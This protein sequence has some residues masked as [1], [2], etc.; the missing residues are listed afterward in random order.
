MVDITTICSSS[1]SSTLYGCNNFSSSEYILQQYIG[2]FEN[3][4]YQSYIPNAYAMGKVE[5]L[6]YE[7]GIMIK[8]ENGWNAS[9]VAKID[10]FMLW[11]MILNML[12]QIT[13]NQ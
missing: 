12:N 10:D 9:K 5:M 2:A 13:L 3:V 1:A 4:M 8:V 11:Q 6:A 7:Y